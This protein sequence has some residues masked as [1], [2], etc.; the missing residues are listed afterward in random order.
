MV[1]RHDTPA[2]LCDFLDRVREVLDQSW[3]YHASFPSHP[4]QGRVTECLDLLH[5]LAEF[6]GDVQRMA[7]ACSSFVVEAHGLGLSDDDVRK[8]VGVDLG[9]LALAHT[10]LATDLSIAGN[11]AI[12]IL[13]ETNAHA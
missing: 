9:R 11:R 3:F 5:L 8:L 1:T 6:T 10:A 7:L 13:G 4:D 12:D 2:E